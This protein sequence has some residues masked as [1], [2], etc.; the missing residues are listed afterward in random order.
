MLY[1]GRGKTKEVEQGK[2]LFGQLHSNRFLAASVMSVSW[3]CNQKKTA[4]K[5]KK[6]TFGV[7]CFVLYRHGCGCNGPDSCG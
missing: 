2:D 7:S 4:D 3:K 1:T 6:R 5:S